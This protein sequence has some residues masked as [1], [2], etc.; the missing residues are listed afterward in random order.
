MRTNDFHLAN[1]QLL[2]GVCKEIPIR[3]FD[4]LL[5]FCT[6]Q[7]QAGI[8]DSKCFAN[9]EHS[10]RN[11]PFFSRVELFLSEHFGLDDKMT[12]RTAWGLALDNIWFE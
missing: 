1:S 8:F 11:I 3:G 10:K 12:S 5:Q 2:F 9:D 7:R 6:T 4:L